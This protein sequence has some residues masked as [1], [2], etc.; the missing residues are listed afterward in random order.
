MFAAFACAAAAGAMPAAAQSAAERGTI[1][2]LATTREEP[3]QIALE[4]PAVAA[5]DGFTVHRKP[6]ETGSWGEVYATLPADATRFEDN[7]LKTGIGYEYRIRAAAGSDSD[8]ERFAP[9]GHACCGIRLPPADDRGAALILVDASMATPLAAEIS[10]LEHDLVGD[11][12]TVLRRET[13]RQS[14]VNAPGKPAEVEAVKAL[15]REAFRAQPDRLRA[16]FLL[17]RV[18]VPYSGWLSPDGHGHTPRAADTYYS[19]PEET[20]TDSRD[21]GPGN[22][23]GDGVFDQS[24]FD[25]RSRQR[26]PVQG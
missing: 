6:M 24:R 25:R 3:P 12:W 8:E 26:R 17:G 9:A 20:W 4:W 18:P 13:A 10:R 19:M 14:A 23:A 5:S 15:I 7:D 21:Y 22:L 1:T 11:G 16:V 2:V